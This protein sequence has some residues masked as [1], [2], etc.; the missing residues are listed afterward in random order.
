MKTPPRIAPHILSLL[1]ISWFVS[2]SAVAAEADTS[3]AAN[4]PVAPQALHTEEKA[5][6]VPARHLTGTLGLEYNQDASVPGQEI[7]QKNVPVG[8]SFETETYVL[9]VNIPYIQRSAPSGKVARS[10]HHESKKDTT[11]APIVTSAGLG[12]VT[13]SLR[14]TLLNEKDA[15]FSLYARGEVKLATADVASGLGTGA[16]DY[17]AELKASKTFGAFTG[18]AS[19]GY[20]IMG[21]PGE[22]KIN[23]VKKFLYFNN[24][25]F[26][27]VGG[28]Y[29]FTESL[30][31][32]LNM[33]LGQ[34]TE[35]GG[36]Q[37]RDLSAGMEFKF[38]TNQ[39]IRMLVLKSFT[40]GIS[41][42]GA[43]AYLSSAL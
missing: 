32:E 42:W 23:D 33:E 35:A 5:A 36:P 43:G 7:I 25:Y 17:S 6:E 38:A 8:F 21:S 18:S 39:S 19:I 34:A 22:V 28:L 15:P 20:A 9:E 24:I 4:I 10:H 16:N 14:Y 12:D 30:H 41:S 2:Q 27:S 26:G 37:Q 11:I 29:Q 13:S 1:V 31:A 3:E 40:P